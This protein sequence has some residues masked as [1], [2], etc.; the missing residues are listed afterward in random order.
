MFFRS[1]RLPVCCDRVCLLASTPLRACRLKLK[2]I[3]G[4]NSVRR[5]FR[6]RIFLSAKIPFGENSI[7]RKFLRRKFLRR[8]FFRRKLLAPPQPHRC[9]FASRIVV[10]LQIDRDWVNIPGEIMRFHLTH[11][12]GPQSVVNSVVNKLKLFDPSWKSSSVLYLKQLWESSLFYKVW[13]TLKSY[14]FK[15]DKN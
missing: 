12:I 15:L 14:A 13:I 5:K 6:R 7:R 2:D 4:E 1:S 9:L 10:V 11:C 3:F 8:K